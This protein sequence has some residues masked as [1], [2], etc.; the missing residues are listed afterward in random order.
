[1][2]VKSERWLSIVPWLAAAAPFAVIACRG[3]PAGEDWKLELTRIAAYSQALAD[4]QTPPYWAPY[5]YGGYGSPVFLFYGQVFLVLASTVVAASSHGQGFVIALAVSSAIGLWSLQR[6]A[7]ELGSGPAARA[8]GRVAAYLFLLNP[9][10]LADALLRN[11]AAE[12]CALCL[13]PL[14]LYGFWLRERDPLRGMLWLAVGVALVMMTHVLVA[15]ALLLML[16]PPALVALHRNG[17]RWQLLGQL[18]VGC[19]LGLVLSAFAW[20]PALRLGSLI[21]SEDLISGKFAWRLHF[22]TASEWFGGGRGYSAGVLPLLAAGA[23]WLAL[24]RATPTRAGSDP[25]SGLLAA[26]ALLIFVQTPLAIPLWEHLPLLAYFQ[27]P[28]RFMGPLALA[29]ALLASCAFARLTQSF[30]ARRRIQIELLIAA[31]CALN[32]LPIFP[33]MRAVAWPEVARFENV[34][35][36]ENQ[37]G[38]L[39]T[40]TV[41]DEYLPRDAQRSGIARSAIEEPITSASTGMRIALRR[42]HPRELVLD[43]RADRDGEVC[44]ARWAF[45]FWTVTVDHALQPIT[46]CRNGVSP[47]PPASITYGRS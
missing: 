26:L 23:A 27:F 41:G 17:A 12:Y 5:L 21:R 36:R 19:S 24:R 28:W 43:V 20:L 47:Y 14:A 1:M 29:S 11:A 40:G 9:Y 22:Q 32:A 10:V 8:S 30:P 2:I 31:V 45:P 34:L 38:L 13:A 16:G 37:R 4:G 3:F 46:A 44:L 25:I 6:T 35:M 39:L 7:A 42:D 18:G 33:R 15:S